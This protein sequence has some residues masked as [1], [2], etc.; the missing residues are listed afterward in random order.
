MCG[1][2]QEQ[3]AKWMT[4]Q[5]MRV[6]IWLLPF[7]AMTVG[8]A[9]E[10]VAAIYGRA[11]MPAAEVLSILIFSAIGAAGIALCTSV[12]VAVGR[13]RF[14]LLV[15]G[16]ALPVAVA[17]HWLTVPRFGMTGAAAVTTCLTWLMAVG[18]AIQIGRVWQ[19]RPPLATLLRSGLVSALALM[20]SWVWPETMGPLP[21]KLAAIGALIVAAFAL[22]GELSRA[23]MQTLRRLLFPRS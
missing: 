18:M 3:Y 6:V 12:L 22:L 10:V 17:G 14:P 16:L 5:A 8:V 19:V 1:Q 15:A 4:R 7:A 23:E 20:L 13:P 2:G 11:F 9:T 21:I